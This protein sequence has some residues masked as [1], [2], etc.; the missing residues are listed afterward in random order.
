MPLSRHSHRGSRRAVMVMHRCLTYAAIAAS[1]YNNGFIIKGN[2][3]RVDRTGEQN[4]RQRIRRYAYTRI[5]NVDRHTRG[6]KAIEHSNCNCNCANAKRP[7]RFPG[8]RPLGTNGD[9]CF[10]T[11]A[12]YFCVFLRRDSR[13]D[14]RSSGILRNEFRFFL[15]ANVRKAHTRF[16]LDL[17]SIIFRDGYKRLGFLPTRILGGAVRLYAH[18]AFFLF[19][20][21]FTSLSI[22]SQLLRAIFYA[23]CRV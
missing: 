17:S 13:F 7:E 1:T 19:S 9:I 15:S 2:T 12:T 8:T 16:V 11:R 14:A 21:F 18:R 3:P 22:S 5:P 10:S 6:T 23:R 20:F 4:E